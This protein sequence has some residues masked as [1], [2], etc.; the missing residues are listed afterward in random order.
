MTGK[1]ASLRVGIL[2]QMY[3]LRNKWDRIP[4]VTE[5]TSKRGASPPSPDDLSGREGMEQAR[6]VRPIGGGSAGIDGQGRGAARGGD[7]GGPSSPAAARPLGS[8]SVDGA[9]PPV[10]APEEAVEWFAELLEPLALLALQRGVRLTA[11]IDSLKLALVRAASGLP[12]ESRD[13]GRDEPRDGDQDE[14]RDGGQV[15]E[16]GRDASAGRV[17]AGGRAS[18]RS[19]SRLAVMTGVHRKDLRRIRTTGSTTRSKSLSIVGEVFARW[20]TSPRFVTRRGEPRVLLRQAVGGDRP[21]FEEL[22]Q[23][24]TRDV[25]PRPVLDEMLRLGMVESDGKAGDRLRLLQAAYVPAADQVEQM[26]LA[27]DNL[28]DHVAAIAA[29]LQGAGGRFLEQAVYSD[30]LTAASARQFNRETLDAWQK[31]FDQVMPRLQALH[32]ADRQS[33]EPRDHRVRLG[34]Y[35]LATRVRE[36]PK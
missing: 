4:I 7:G 15:D 8:T 23:A 35:G 33:S 20:R 32:E 22:V 3:R 1:A 6:V 17:G 19:D 34:M 27:R 26:R 10:L 29:N 13:G 14:G 11:L 21:S 24:V 12:G 28:A 36:T 30:E 5:S 9:G 16:P 2:S 25:H 18:G 31:L